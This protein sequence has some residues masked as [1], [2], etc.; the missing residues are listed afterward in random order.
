M[1]A[2]N[3]MYKQTH[4]QFTT[5]LLVL[6]L[7]PWAGQLAPDFH[8]RNNYCLGYMTVLLSMTVWVSVTV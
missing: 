8:V 1:G 3:N 7:N 4:I 2:R 6:L 5:F